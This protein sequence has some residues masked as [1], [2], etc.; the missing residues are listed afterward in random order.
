MAKSAGNVT[1]EINP[2]ET[3]VSRIVDYRLAMPAAAA[4]DAIW[5]RYLASNEK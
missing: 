3:S 1:V 5:N 2:S 4:L